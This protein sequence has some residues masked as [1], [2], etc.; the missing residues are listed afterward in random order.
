M[1][2][3]LLSIHD[4]ASFKGK[5]PDESILYQIILQWSSDVITNLLHRLSKVAM[6][7]KVMPK[8]HAQNDGTPTKLNKEPVQEIETTLKET[9]SV[10]PATTFKKGDTNNKN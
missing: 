8:P 7:E 6:V 5:L 10:T 2:Q 3:E 1:N 9:V 4:R